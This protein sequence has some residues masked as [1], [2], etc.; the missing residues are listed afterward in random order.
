MKYQARLAPSMRTVGFRP[1][2]EK[3][4]TDKTIIFTPDQSFDDL[5]ERASRMEVLAG[6]PDSYDPENTQLTAQLTRAASNL[7]MSTAAG[8]NDAAQTHTKR[9][10]HVLSVPDDLIS[11]FGKR[12]ATKI[13]LGRYAVESGKLYDLSLWRAI[14]R[15]FQAEFWKSTACLFIACE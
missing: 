3:T 13:R 6:L 7:Q 2:S 1:Q 10:S 9:V 5:D 8:E 4:N 11:R 14:Y 12:N 15:T